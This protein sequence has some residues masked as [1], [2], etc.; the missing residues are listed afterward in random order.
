MILNI[1]SDNDDVD[2]LMICIERNQM[3]MIKL[4]ISIQSET[5]LVLN[6]NLSVH[7]SRSD[8]VNRFE[9]SFIRY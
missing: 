3:D 5:M 4:N 7:H 8:E 2:V 1:I 9:M 6:K